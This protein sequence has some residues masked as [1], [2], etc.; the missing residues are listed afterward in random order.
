MEPEWKY[1]TEADEANAKVFLNRHL[2][3]FVKSPPRRLYHYTSGNNLIRII[4][5]QELWTTQIACL[6]DTKELTH[7][8]EGMLENIKMRLFASA[9]GG[10][11][12]RLLPGPLEMRLRT[13]LGAPRETLFP[14]RFQEKHYDRISLQSE[15]QVFVSCFSEKKDDLSQWRAYSGGEGGYMIE[16][17]PDA[18]KRSVIQPVGLGRVEYDKKRQLKLI[19]AMLKEAERIYL[20]SEGAKSRRKHED[21]WALE[22]VRLWLQN[23]WILALFLK[24][25]SFAA[26]QEWRLVLSLPPEI[27]ATRFQQRS[28][29]MSRH[30]PLTFANK[31]LPIVGICVGPCRYP[32]L[33]RIALADLLRSRRYNLDDIE[34]SITSVPYR[35][36]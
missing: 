14:L 26:E 20:K 31:K 16:F 25:P 17:D 24:H 1:I 5:N 8:L 32:E 19:N 12:K 28:S 34:L 9:L 10:R 11:P 27:S 18:L 13:V 15:A 2:P 30:L 35:L 23:V 21:E 6:N 22:C 33:S 29:M 3:D 7:A 4:E 36:P